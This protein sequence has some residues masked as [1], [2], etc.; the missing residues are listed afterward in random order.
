M[1][2]VTDAQTDSRKTLEEQISRPTPADA[3]PLRVWTLRIHEEV[4]REI[5]N[6]ARLKRMSVNGYVVWLFDQALRQDGRPSVT[7]LA[8]EFVEYLRRT[9]GKKKPK[10][11][12]RSSEFGFS[13][14]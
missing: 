9:G 6:L 3:L 12:R 11:V 2:E 7:E 4:A 10:A 5:E 13:D 1:S 8:P 14:E